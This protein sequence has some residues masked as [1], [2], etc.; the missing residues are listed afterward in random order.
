MTRTHRPDR[1]TAIVNAGKSCEACLRH[2]HVLRQRG[3]DLGADH[4]LQQAAT[5][6][7][8][9]FTRAMQP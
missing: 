6:S 7:R 4:A 8:I 1:K 5:W 9:A 2:A 3:D